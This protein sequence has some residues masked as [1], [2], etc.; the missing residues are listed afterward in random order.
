MDHIDRVTR[1]LRNRVGAMYEPEE[2]TSPRAIVISDTPAKVL[3]RLSHR[4]GS[5]QGSKQW[6]N[7]RV[8]RQRRAKAT[9]GFTSRNATIDKSF[10][11]RTLTNGG[12]SIAKEIKFVPSLA[13]GDD[14]DL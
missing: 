4:R 11:A 9:L 7:P 10:G 1:P 13:G 12:V 6:A 14:L 5:R 3:Y 2:L 8:A